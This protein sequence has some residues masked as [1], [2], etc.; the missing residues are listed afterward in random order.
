MST[1]SI[2]HTSDGYLNVTAEYFTPLWATST[3]ISISSIFIICF[4][5]Y[6]IFYF[7]FLIRMRNRKEFKRN[8]KILF[9]LVGV[10]VTF[11]FMCLVMSIVYNILNKNARF[12]LEN[13]AN[14]TWAF[15]I[16]LQTALGLNNF[17]RFTNVVILFVIIYFVQMIFWKTARLTRTISSLSFRYIKILMNIV[18]LAFVVTGML[19]VMVVVV[20]DVLL[21]LGYISNLITTGVYVGCFFCIVFMI[22]FDSIM[23]LTS[24]ILVINTIKRTAQNAERMTNRFTE[25]APAATKKEDVSLYQEST[26]E[27]NKGF[28]KSNETGVRFQKRVQNP[29]KM[30]FG[31][32]FALVMCVVMEVVAGATGSTSSVHLSLGLIWHFCNSSGIFCFAAA[33]L[34]LFYPSILVTN[35]AIQELEKQSL[36]TAQQA[37]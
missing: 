26:T 30:T 16:G 9:V 3:S 13:G 10:C 4:V 1:L 28:P 33:V 20:S 23:A 6:F 18:N 17:F 14:V 7:I 15:F 12:Q 37:I 25:S 19:F 8:H 24:G 36:G 22:V 35:D 29:F 31:L 21:R 11:Q 34:I 32:L 2:S 5:L 27:Q